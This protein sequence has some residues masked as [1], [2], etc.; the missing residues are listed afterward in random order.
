[1]AMHKANFSTGELA[2]RILQLSSSAGGQEQ[3]LQMRT[4]LL[5]TTVS[6]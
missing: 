6:K 3:N 1:M 5:L 4:L 2:F